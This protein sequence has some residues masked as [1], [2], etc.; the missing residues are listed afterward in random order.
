MVKT[1][2]QRRKR[3]HGSCCSDQAFTAELRVLAARSRTNSFSCSVLFLL[4]RASVRFGPRD[5]FTTFGPR[6]VTVKYRFRHGCKILCLPSLFCWGAE[7]R[8]TSQSWG[9]MGALPIRLLPHQILHTAWQY[10]VGGYCVNPNRWKH[11]YVWG[12]CWSGVAL[13]PPGECKTTWKEHIL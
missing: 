1:K 5:Y 13:V 7:M 9:S 12:F 4:R 6:Y 11:L 2:T 10:Q 3:S 8:K